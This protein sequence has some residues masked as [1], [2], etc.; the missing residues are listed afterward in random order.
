MFKI[1]VVFNS[2]ILIRV[3]HTLYHFLHITIKSKFSVLLLKAYK[4]LS[5]DNG[6]TS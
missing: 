4:G 2:V 3:L 1:S 6:R 5:R